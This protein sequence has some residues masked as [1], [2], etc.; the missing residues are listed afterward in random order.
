MGLLRRRKERRPADEP[1][2]DEP[3]PEM[4]T[5]TRNSYFGFLI[6]LLDRPSRKGRRREAT[7]PRDANSAHSS[8]G[9]AAVL[10]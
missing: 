8:H 1:R 9:P 3:P 7:A 2:A 5:W 10:P 6:G 4:D